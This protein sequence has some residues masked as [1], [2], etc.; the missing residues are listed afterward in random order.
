LNTRQGKLNVS[1]ISDRTA[2][3]FAGMTSDSCFRSL[4]KCHR[5]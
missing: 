1:A 2:G 5:V 3:L 4:H